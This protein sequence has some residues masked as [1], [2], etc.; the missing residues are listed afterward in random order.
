[1]VCVDV[2]D[3]KLR[4]SYVERAREGLSTM[5]EKTQVF[6]MS[7]NDYEARALIELGLG[8]EEWFSSLDLPRVPS[9]STSAQAQWGAKT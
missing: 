2:R 9:I 1:M 6:G 8:I 3:H 4:L 7:S 5:D